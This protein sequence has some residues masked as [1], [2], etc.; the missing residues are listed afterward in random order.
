MRVS[1]FSTR[2]K[3][4]KVCILTSEHRAVDQRIFHKEAVSLAGNGYEVHI[5]GDHHKD[6]VLNGVYIHSM[7]RPKNRLFRKLSSSWRFFFKAV[8]ENADI[9]HFHDPDLIFCGLALQIFGKKVIMDVHEDFQ[10]TIIKKRRCF[11]KGVRY[12]I[13]AT[14][15]TIEKI[16][17]K[18]FSGVIVVN[19]EMVRKFPNV[20]VA[21]VRNFPILDGFKREDGDRSKI[22]SVIYTGSIGKSRGCWQI[23]E[24][25]KI[26]KQ[27][28]TEVKLTIIGSFANYDFEQKFRK[29]ALA[30]GS[31]HILGHLPWEEVRQKQRE[32]DVGLLISL[33]N[34]DSLERT[35]PVKL[36]EYM[37][38]GLP[39]VISNKHYWRQLL[40]QCRFGLMVKDANSNEIADALFTLATNKVLMR[41][42]GLAGKKFVE[43]NFSWNTE[44]NKMKSLYESIIGC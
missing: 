27:K 2:N 24:G 23:I 9:Y 31:V 40:G 16:S 5:L 28:Y 30:I 37:S 39:V 26:F 17:S 35:Y 36:F 3:W 15:N 6:E 33:Y 12:L 11:T 8:G 29:K 34:K 43:Q 25:F 41:Q 44:F 19:E 20:N 18:I 22:V 10:A 32:A 13:A 14:F 42:M 21:V 7:Y 1:R 4:T 38:A